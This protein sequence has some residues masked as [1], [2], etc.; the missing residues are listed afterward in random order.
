MDNLGITCVYMD[1]NT[2]R[3][4]CLNCGKV[5]E[6]DLE[7]KNFITNEWDEHTYKCNC[8]PGMRISIG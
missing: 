8:M 7:A 3:I 4:K 2:E 5:F 6:P 1:E